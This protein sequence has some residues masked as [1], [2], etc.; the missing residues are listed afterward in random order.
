VECM[1]I[2]SFCVN[3]CMAA[4]GDT[5][6]IHLVFGFYLNCFAMMNT[7]QTTRVMWLNFWGFFGVLG[8]GRLGKT[9]AF[10]INWKLNA[11]RT[12]IRVIRGQNWWGYHKHLLGLEKLG[13][14]DELS[15][16]VVNCTI[17]VAENSYLD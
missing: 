10:N 9:R 11:Y 1:N 8:W 17:I 4:R 7:R 6:L 15:V 14:F 16:M 13:G 5:W 12:E 2:L 3:F